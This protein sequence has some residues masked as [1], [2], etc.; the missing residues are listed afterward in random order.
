MSKPKKEATVI[1]TV[2]ITSIVK[3]PSNGSPEAEVTSAIESLQQILKGIAMIDKVDTK[4]IKVFLR[5]GG[6]K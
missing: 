3:I 5:E 1:T 6:S 4:K 2:E